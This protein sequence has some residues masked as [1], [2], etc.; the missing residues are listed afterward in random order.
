MRRMMKLAALDV[1]TNSVLML[2]AESRPDGGVRP[3]LELARITRLGRGVERTGAL[4]PEAARLTLD[5]IV[6]FAAAARAAGCAT[7]VAVATSVLRD[8]ADGAAFLARARE[9]AGVEVEVISGRAEAELSHRAAMRGLG[10]D[11]GARVL[12]VDI[13]GGSTELVA[14]A[15]GREL[16]MTSLKLGSVRLTERIVHHDPPLAAEINELQATIDAALASL[17]WDLR[18]ETLVG[19][20]GTVTTICAIALGMEV[21]DHSRVHGYVL[22]RGEVSRIRK[23][24]GE[25]S[26]AERMKLKGLPQGRADIIFAGAMILERIMEHFAASSVTVSDQG[27]RW[28]LIWRELDRLGAAA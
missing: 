11:P 23:Q 13:G 17:R 25:L 10:L 12:T 9:R 3:L 2:A 15:P 28:G 21:Y 16:A 19:I 7:I 4:D 14:A 5:T 22:S 8:A 27:V 6:E 26:L 1:G 18:P 24:L 20:A